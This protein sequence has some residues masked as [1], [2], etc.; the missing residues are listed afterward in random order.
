MTAFLNLI[1]SEMCHP[2]QVSLQPGPS[3][4]CLACSKTVSVYDFI[5]APS[6][7]NYR[8]SRLAQAFYEET[9]DLSVRL[10][11]PVVNLQGIE[12]GTVQCQTLGRVHQSIRLLRDLNSPFTAHPSPRTEKTEN[13]SFLGEFLNI[14]Q[15]HPFE[16]S[17]TEKKVLETLIQCM[18]SLMSTKEDFFE[19]YFTLLVPYVQK[20]TDW[21]PLQKQEQPAGPAEELLFQLYRSH[22]IRRV[23]GKYAIPFD[24]IH[25]MVACFAC[26]SDMPFVANWALDFFVRVCKGHF[27]GS[28]PFAEAMT[29]LIASQVTYRK[30]TQHYQV[31]KAIRDGESKEHYST[32]LQHFH[33]AQT[34]LRD[35]FGKRTDIP[36]PLKDVAFSQ[37]FP[38]VLFKDYRDHL[39]F[40]L[41]H[42]HVLMTLS[43]NHGKV[44][45][46]TFKTA[47][48]IHETVMRII[49]LVLQ[50]ETIPINW[51]LSTLELFMQMDGNNVEKEILSVIGMI[52]A[53]GE[54]E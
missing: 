5:L 42:N 12:D 14:L 32:F 30:N 9:G 27:S 1:R 19:T 45:K 49:N 16:C 31:L 34:F 48:H 41:G 52:Q 39:G 35:H 29:K 8:S 51:T 33:E 4:V 23:F 36:E 6:P 11:V 53:E 3:L 13:F 40:M 50:F 21:R 38:S 26:S 2:D 10:N 20:C 54:V 25:V 7:D 37:N 18:H 17:A 28:Q 47:K 44:P 24:L 22:E 46:G 15:E 43:R